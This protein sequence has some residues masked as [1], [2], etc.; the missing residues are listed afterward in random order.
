VGTRLFLN[1]GKG[2]FH[3]AP[4][5]GLACKYGATTLALADVNGDGYL[6]LYVANYRTTTIRTTGLPLLKI[7]GKLSI[8]PEDREDYELT[9]QGRIIEH[10]EPHFL[11]LNDPPATSADAWTNGAPWTR[12]SDTGQARDGAS[13]AFRD[14][15]GDRALTLRLQRFR[16]SRPH[17]DQ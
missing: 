6:D 14:L 13:I 7:N 15:N 17:L 3:E 9:P 5:S 10:G 4:K 1:D 11:Y 16:D 8:R 12:W 2:H